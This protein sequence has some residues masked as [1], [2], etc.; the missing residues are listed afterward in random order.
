LNN[1]TLLT[2]DG[3]IIQQPQG[4]LS[5]AMADPMLPAAQAY[6]QNM[7]EAVRQQ[8]LQAFAHLF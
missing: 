5:R 1:L 2:S 4:D 7:P 3:Q 6:S 8:L